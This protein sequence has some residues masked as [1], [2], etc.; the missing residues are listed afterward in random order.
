MNNEFHAFPTSLSGC[1][2]R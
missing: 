1:L 2:T